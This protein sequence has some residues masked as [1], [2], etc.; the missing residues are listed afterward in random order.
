VIPSWHQPWARA[1]QQPCSTLA[2]QQAQ[3]PQRQQR[4]ERQN[5][6]V[7]DAYQAEVINLNAWHSRR[8]KLTGELPQIEQERAQFV[9]TP[10]QTRHGQQVI[11][12]AETFR[13]LLGNN[14]DR[15]SCEERQVVVQC[16]ISKVVV[17][18]DHVDIAYVLPVVEAPRVAD[19]PEYT[20]GGTPGQCYRLRLAHLDLGAEAIPLPDLRRG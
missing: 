18:A 19:H 7:L 20:P 17:M 1:E 10:Q 5:Q 3:L 4:L 11:D 2:A 14:L 15:L 13:Q 8:L 16:L 12:H 9:R 6:R